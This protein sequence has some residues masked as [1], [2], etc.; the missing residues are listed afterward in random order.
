MGGDE[1]MHTCA[2]TGHRKIEASHMG[3]IENLLSRAVDF[4]YENGCRTF[5]TGGALGFDTI[6]AREVILFKLSHPDV[7]LRLL[8]PCQDQDSSWSS[9][10]RVAYAHVIENADFVEYA[11]DFYTPGCMQKR[12][13]LLAE[14][15]DILVAYLGRARSGA[16][17]TVRLATGLGKRVFNLYNH[18]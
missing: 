13:R 10:Q 17:Q 18:C 7:T 4:A 14:R 6:A 12:N 9:R 15:C 2:F 1:R 8:L 16:G 5:I 11:E 3:K